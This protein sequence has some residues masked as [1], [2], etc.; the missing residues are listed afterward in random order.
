M[1]NEMDAWQ[2]RY[3][4]LAPGQSAWYWHR[5]KGGIEGLSDQTRVAY[6]VTRAVDGALWVQVGELPLPVLAGFP[7]GDRCW[8]AAEMAAMRTRITDLEDDFRST[9]AE[10]CGDSGDDRVH[11]ACVP[12]LRR[13]IRELEAEQR[14][15]QAD[16]RWGRDRIRELTEWLDGVETALRTNDRTTAYEE[17]PVETVAMRVAQA[18]RDAYLR[19]RHDESYT[20]S[21][22]SMGRLNTK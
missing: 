20:V 7:C 17:P 21:V 4:D 1:T 2:A 5:P 15:L 6:Q 12:H 18:L 8:E 9:V 16:R 3:A 14:S 19:G 11:C 10:V 22:G 13:K